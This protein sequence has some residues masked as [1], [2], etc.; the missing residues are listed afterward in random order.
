VW[1]D[2]I[3][4]IISISVSSIKIKLNAWHKLRSTLLSRQEHGPV[5]AERHSSGQLNLDSLVM[6]Y[7]LVNFL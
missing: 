1:G 4:I 7:I 5:L 6:V 3:L 2:G